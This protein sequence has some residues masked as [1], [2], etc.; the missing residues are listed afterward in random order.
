[1]TPETP[2]PKAEAPGVD[3]AGK[4]FELNDGIK[5][6]NLGDMGYIYGYPDATFGPKANI[7]RAEFA[8]ILYRVFAFDNKTVTTKF[9][10]VPSRAWYAPAVELLASRGIIYGVGNGKFEPR[11]SYTMLL[12]NVTVCSLEIKSFILKSFRK[13]A[14]PLLTTCASTFDTAL[15]LMDTLSVSVP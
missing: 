13:S 15:D 11:D 4:N 2:T 12:M 14:I 7:T 5:V 6:V 8:S 1:M 9:D 10:D 3:S